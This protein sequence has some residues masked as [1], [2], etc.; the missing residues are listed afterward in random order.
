MYFYKANACNQH[1]NQEN[2]IL[3]HCQPTRGSLPIT[4]HTRPPSP[5]V[6]TSHITDY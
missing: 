6:T 5:K 2:T 1:P 3:V 4:S